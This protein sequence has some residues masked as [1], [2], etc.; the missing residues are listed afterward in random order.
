MAV[1]GLYFHSVER[2]AAHTGRAV[3]RLV[4]HDEQDVVGAIIGERDI[5]RNLGPGAICQLNGAT[6]HKVGG[7]H[8]Y[9]VQVVA[10]GCLVRV[11]EVHIVV[12]GLRCT[13]IKEGYAGNSASPV[14]FRGR[15]D[16]LGEGV[17]GT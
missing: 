8:G 1:Y 6:E 5:E 16:L 13:L 14:D 10:E 15:I 7:G 3:A 2:V 11:N 4:I 12:A 17:I 9:P